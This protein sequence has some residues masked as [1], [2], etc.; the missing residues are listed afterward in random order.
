M[1]LREIIKKNKVYLI[2]IFVLYCIT[3]YFFVRNINFENYYLRLDKKISENKYDNSIL[4]TSLSSFNKEN[5]NKTLNELTKVDGFKG[6]DYGFRIIDNSGIKEEDLKPSA[7]VSRYYMENLKE[8]SSKDISIGKDNHYYAITF[9]N[10]NLVGK[11]FDWNLNGRTIKVEIVKNFDGNILVPMFSSLNPNQHNARDIF[12]YADGIYLID[13][14]ELLDLM[15]NEKGSRVLCSNIM[16]Y[17]SKNNDDKIIDLRK[18]LDSF[19]FTKSINEYKGGAKKELLDIKRQTSF[20]PRIFSVI[21]FITIISIAI[22]SSYRLSNDI[23]VLRLNGLSLKKTLNLL[24]T[25]FAIV[26]LPPFVI[27]LI[28]SVFKT[29]NMKPY[30]ITRSN[31]YYTVRGI[32]LYLIFVLISILSTYIITRHMIKINEKEGIINDKA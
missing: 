10:K 7:I 8:G 2:L 20:L 15:M 17:Y 30:L 3:A 27:G 5:F 12:A 16:A 11:A 13:D 28:Y 21:S 23:K 1:I 24:V 18:T 9:N 25:Q 14:G 22:L 6:A 26:S 31:R 4:V 32:N 29:I 19:S